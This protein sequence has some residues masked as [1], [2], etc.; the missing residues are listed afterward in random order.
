MVRRSFIRKCVV[1]VAGAIDVA[2]S[3]TPSGLRALLPLCL[4][5]L[6]LT[7]FAASG[8][9]HSLHYEPGCSAT[10]QKNVARQVGVA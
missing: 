4:H 6:L 7:V 9:L 10:R 3:V 2:Y 8:F 5:A 1:V